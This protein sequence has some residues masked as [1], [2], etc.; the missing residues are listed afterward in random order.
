MLTKSDKIKREKLFDKCM[1][2]GMQLMKFKNVEY[3]VHAVSANNGFGIDQLK[4][5]LVEAFERY[6]T[7]DLKGKEETLIKLLLE[8][9]TLRPKKRHGL[10]LP[11]FRGAKMGKVA[12]NRKTNLIENEKTTG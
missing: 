2:V 5:S 12:G 7:R 9:K 8:N 10:K 3:L 6:P 4:A 11:K 1:A